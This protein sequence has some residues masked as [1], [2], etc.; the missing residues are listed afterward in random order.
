MATKPSFKVRHQEWNKVLSDAVS[1]A[2]SDQREKKLDNWRHFPH[3][4]EMHPRG[5]AEHFLPLLVA[6]GAAGDGTCKKFSDEFM[7]FTAWTYYWAED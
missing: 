6:A 1:E 2:N 3:A 5:G 7:G 4:Y